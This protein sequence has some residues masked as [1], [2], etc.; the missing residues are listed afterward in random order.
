[1]FNILKNP[2]GIIGLLNAGKDIKDDFSGSVN[3]GVVTS[4]FP[5]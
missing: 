5:F 4:F 2:E 3:K 1:V